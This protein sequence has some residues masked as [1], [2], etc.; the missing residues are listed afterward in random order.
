M[1]FRLA[2]RGHKGL[3]QCLLR[4]AKRGTMLIANS[5]PRFAI[6]NKHYIRS[7]FLSLPMAII[8]NRLLQIA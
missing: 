8:L 1:L 2:K 4:T 7:I 5:D 6:R 3:V